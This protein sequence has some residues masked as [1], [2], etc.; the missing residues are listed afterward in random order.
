MSA[1]GIVK[2][3]QGMA[4]TYGGSQNPSVDIVFNTDGL[5]RMYGTAFILK[6]AVV[7]DQAINAAIDDLKSEI[8]GLRSEAKQKLRGAN[9]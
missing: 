1:F 7:S 3:Q 8:E 9:D 6:S 4:I 5:T 2:T